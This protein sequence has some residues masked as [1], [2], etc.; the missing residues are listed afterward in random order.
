MRTNWDLTIKLV[1]L[2]KRA[3]WSW[4]SSELQF[5]ENYSLCPLMILQIVID[6]LSNISFPYLYSFYCNT[7]SVFTFYITYIMLNS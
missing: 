7:T 3:C 5:L 2:L 4:E 1:W 6:L